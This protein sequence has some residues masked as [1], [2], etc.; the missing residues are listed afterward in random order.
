M[1][2]VK[3]VK[4]A[5]RCPNRTPI[6]S[7]YESE[8]VSDEDE[9]IDIRSID[10]EYYLSKHDEHDNDDNSN[11]ENYEEHSSDSDSDILS[12]DESQANPIIITNKVDENIFGEWFEYPTMII[13]LKSCHLNQERH[14]L[15]LKYPNQLKSH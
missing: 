5:E 7:D 8:N 12:V 6:L 4:C 10:D 11:I 9:E 3:W 14:P 1:A 13:C 15:V 2:T